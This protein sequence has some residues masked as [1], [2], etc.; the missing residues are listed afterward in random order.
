M[1]IVVDT[2]Y[3]ETL[4]T[5]GILEV[6]FTIITTAKDPLN[7]DACDDEDNVHTRLPNGRA[8]TTATNIHAVSSSRSGILL[9]TNRVLPSTNQAFDSFLHRRAG[10]LFLERR[11]GALLMIAQ[12]IIIGARGKRGMDR[13]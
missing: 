7:H 8:T 6:L 1:S 2:F 12:L 3:D 5:L 10:L 4:A 13:F 9:S 11:W